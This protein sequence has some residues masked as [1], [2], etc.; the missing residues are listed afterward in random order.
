M[1]LKSSEALYSHG[2]GFSSPLLNLT[3]EVISAGL[4]GY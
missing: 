4:T 1:T 3:M 2:T